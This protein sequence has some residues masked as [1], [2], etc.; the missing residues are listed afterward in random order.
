MDF[1]G[2]DLRVRDVMK[3]RAHVCMDKSFKSSSSNLIGHMNRSIEG[4]DMK[5]KIANFILFIPL[6]IYLECAIQNKSLIK[7][8]VKNALLV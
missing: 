5:E 6:F 7:R 4:A 1:N 3:S 2:K 8:N